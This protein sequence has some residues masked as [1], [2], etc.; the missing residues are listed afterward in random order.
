MAE[1]G[2]QKLAEAHDQ[3]ILLSAWLRNKRLAFLPE[4]KG[5][6]ILRANKEQRRQQFLLTQYREFRW[7]I[8]R[9]MNLGQWRHFTCTASEL[10]IYLVCRICTD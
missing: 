10:V 3:G 6:V 7:K 1:P 9:E 5:P 8:H 2:C 4:L